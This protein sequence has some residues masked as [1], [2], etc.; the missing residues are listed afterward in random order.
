LH[1][2]EI[3]LNPLEQARLPFAEKRP[4]ETSHC[5][6]PQEVV[7]QSEIMTEKLVNL[8]NQWVVRNLRVLPVAAT[9]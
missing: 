1:G 6:L 9:A 5:F 8:G 4:T 3:R 2:I 7:L